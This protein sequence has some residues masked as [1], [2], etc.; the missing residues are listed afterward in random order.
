MKRDLVLLQILFKLICVCKKDCD[1]ADGWTQQFKND[2]DQDDDN[3]PWMMM[4]TF[5]SSRREA[6]ETLNK[7]DDDEDHR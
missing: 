7:Q 4:D 5:A 1:E 2:E 3:D 6:T